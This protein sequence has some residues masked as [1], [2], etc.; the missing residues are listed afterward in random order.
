MVNQIIG[1]KNQGVSFDHFSRT[2]VN[3]TTFGGGQA[4]NNPD[5]IITFPTQSFILTIE[6]SGTVEY[7][8]NGNT[9]AGELTN[10]GNRAQLTFNNRVASLIWFRL[11]T[12]SS[13]PINVTV[14]AWA[15]R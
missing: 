2:A 7:S 1:K 10:G 4:N 14:D 12:G 6:G 11:K 5:V 3:W 15:I 13:G 8:F 9:I